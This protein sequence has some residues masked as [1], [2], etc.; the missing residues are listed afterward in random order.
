MVVLDVPPIGPLRPAALDANQQRVVAHARGP[1][2]V[3]AGPGT[4]KSTTIVE[5]VA[6]RLSGSDGNPVPAD[7]VLVLTFGRKAADEIRDRIA[8]RLQGGALPLV[9]TFHSYSYSIVREFADPAEFQAPPRLLSGPEQEH[10][11]REL[12]TN[13]IKDG[14]VSWPADLEPAVGTRGLAALVRELIAKAQALDISAQELAALGD[15]AG[16]P[17]WSSIAGFLDEYL[18]VLDAEGVMDYAELIHRAVALAGL[19][20][21]G[22]KLRS[23]YQAIFVDEYQDTD[24]AQVRLLQ[25]IT[26]PTT[27][28]VAVGDPDQ[29]IYGFRG[30]DVG[31]ILRFRDDF[32]T[33]DGSPAP[34]EVLSTTRRFGEGIRDAAG[35]VIRR[36]SLGTLPAEV[37]KAHRLPDCTAPT[38]GDVRV[39]TFDSIAAQAASVADEVRRARLNGDVQRWSDIAILVRSSTRDIAALQQ[40]LLAA[41]VP[42][43]VPGDDIPLHAQPGI[44]PLLDV[45]RVAATPE[46]LTSDRARRLLVSPLVGMDP[47]GLRRLGR[48]L[49]GLDAGET[50]PSTRSSADLIRDAVADR[51]LLIEVDDRSAEPVRRLTNILSVAREAIAANEPVEQ[52]LWTVWS[53][54]TWPKRLQH[55]AMTEGAPGRAADRDLDAAVA[56]FGLA[57]RADTAFDGRRGVANFLAELDRQSLATPMAAGATQNRDAVALMTAH[58][59]KGLQWRRVYVVGVQEGQWPDLRIRG[60]LLQT[61]RLDVTGL[62]APKTVADMLDEERRLFFVACTRAQEALTVT[63]VRSFDDSG[64]QPSRF[65]EAFAASVDVDRRHEG[66]YLAAPLSLAALVAELRA[67]VEDPQA[68]ETLRTIAAGR[69][70][71]L[72][73]QGVT[74]ADPANWWGVPDWTDNDEPVRDPAQPLR[75]SG[76]AWTGIDSCSLAWFLDREVNGAVARG[77]APA[78]GSVVH[79]LADAV[80]R[81]ELEA[82]TDVLVARAEQVWAGIGYEADWQAQEELIAVRT[83]L[84]LFVLWHESRPDREVLATELKFAAGLD[85]AEDSLAVNGVIDRLERDADGMLHI[86]DLKTQRTPPTAKEVVEHLQLSLYQLVGEEH[87]FDD[88]AENNGVAGAELVQLRNPV[89]KTGQP[90]VQVQVPVDVEAVKERLADAVEIVRSEHFLPD[91]VNGMCRNCQFLLVCPAQPQGSQVTL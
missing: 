28:L 69:L 12:L 21:I 11:V 64:A 54:T 71:M 14:R 58:R 89:A 42:V 80:G 56:L 67:Q 25:R 15:E 40:A 10:R 81:G 66:G 38:R 75:F 90:K 83:A 2:L 59:A 79:A 4:G 70:A 36:V 33:V 39:R 29:A 31:G 43:A 3:L 76:S 13:S 49:R 17:V 51:A 46:A 60:S 52:V 5:A 6:G 74:V 20:D 22:A 26:T 50:L 30:A 1:L 7:Q 24:V 87:V 82:D 84:D 9:S 32:T 45:L 53:A 68:G 88:Q 77:A 16:V 78:F 55:A 62:V 47:S 63:A 48:A 72:A 34:I 35:R 44:A 27:S 65:L 86:I 91:P 57:A 18:D 37:Q 19:P 41:G 8:R 85:I 73:G 61:D 23:R